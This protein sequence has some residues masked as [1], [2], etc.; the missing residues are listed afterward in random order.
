MTETKKKWKKELKLTLERMGNRTTSEEKE[1]EMEEK[2]RIRVGCSER[3]EKNNN[4]GTQRKKE[5][6]RRRRS[7]ALIPPSSVKC[8][9]FMR[10][11]RAREEAKER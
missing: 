7:G 8:D 4:V 9:S 1:G 6:R 5:R 10:N 2:C 11:M 3:R